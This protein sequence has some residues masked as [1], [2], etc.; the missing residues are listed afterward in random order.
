MAYR[1]VKAKPISYGA[2]RSKKSIKYIVIHYTGNDH[3]GDTAAAEC[4]FFKNGNTREAGAHFF[5]DQ[6]GK[7][8]KSIAMNLTAYSVGG[9]FT[10]ANGAGEYYKKCT[11][12]NSV[13]IELCDCASRDP[14]AAMIKA[15]KKLIKY[16]RK[17][18]P[19]A[20][21]VIRHWQVN[22]K[23]CPARM[24]GPNNSRWDD[25]LDDIGESKP[26][27]TANLELGDKGEQVKKLQS[28]LNKLNK[29]K[30]KIDGSYGPATEKA[31]R[32]FQKKYKLEVDGICGPKT[33]SK[34][35]SLM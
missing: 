19:N 5:V 21:T 29:A 33:R 28:C 26:Y 32:A 24:A 14:S 1:Y 16:I 25:F 20:Q 31:V 34:I 30:L 9:Y 17:W 13:S 3:R 10:Q 27:P 11:N 18:C 8:M 23:C 15:V 12:S 2:K 35:K 4:A 6:N 22:G 7:C